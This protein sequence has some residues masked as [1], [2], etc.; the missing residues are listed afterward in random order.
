MTKLRNIDAIKKMLDGTHRMQTRKTISFSESFDKE[1]YQKREVGESWTDENGVEW[2]QRAGF[3]IKKGK[4][5][6]IRDL[7]VANRMPSHCP[8]C[9]EPMKKRLDEKFWKL[10]KRCF[11][12]QVNFEHNL[13]IEGKFEE[14]QRNRILKNAEA[15]L[16]D[17][18]KEAKEIIEVFKNP[19]TFANSDGTFE[20]WTGG[21]T[22]EEVAQQIEEEFDEF[23]KNFIE[24]LKTVEE[25]E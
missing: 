14:Y 19:L 7:L 1:K 4:L 18:E 16:A 8:E 24:K 20:E 21:K 22:A 10:E 3:K 17:A 2:E 12:C 11:D 25:R 5:D 23:K 9:N 6:E 13:R 15:W